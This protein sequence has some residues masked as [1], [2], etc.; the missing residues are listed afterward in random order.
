VSSGLVSGLD[1]VEQKV[2][3]L[4]MLWLF[5]GVML[6]DEDKV[7]LVIVACGSFSPPTYLHL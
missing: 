5:S 4:T 7:P 1:G 3:E 2:E 6:L